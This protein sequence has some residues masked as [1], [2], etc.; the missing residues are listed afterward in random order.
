MNIKVDFK[1]VPFAKAMEAAYKNQI[2]FATANA[3]TT[4]VKQAQGVIQR[5]AESVFTLR[6]KHVPRGIRINPATKRNLTAEVG[7]VDPFMRLQVVGGVKQGEAKGESRAVPGP[8]LRPTKAAR[9]TRGKFPKKLLAKGGRRPPTKVTLKSGAQAI[10]QRVGKAPTP[11]KRLWLLPKQVRVK[12]RLDLEGKVE[13]T[14][15]RH[16][17]DNMIASLDKALRSAT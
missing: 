16:W 14:V 2:P 8:G 13:E 6:N 17:A 12:P 15:Q 10:V 7:S 3:L 1:T 11:L 5:E 9:V 4:T